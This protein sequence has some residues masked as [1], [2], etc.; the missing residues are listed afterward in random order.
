[1]EDAKVSFGFGEG[2]ACSTGFGG[3]WICLPLA[4]SHKP[5]P[6]IHRWVCHPV[7]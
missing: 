5:H 7:L 2:W 6:T 4:A 3:G 1:M